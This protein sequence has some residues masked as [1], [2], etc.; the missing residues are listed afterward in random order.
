MA[1]DDGRREKKKKKKKEEE[2]ETIP[3]LIFPKYSYAVFI[4]N[5][6]VTNKLIV[7][8]FLSSFLNKI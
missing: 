1:G 6:N 5:I 7:C 4:L 8:H 2:E 3:I